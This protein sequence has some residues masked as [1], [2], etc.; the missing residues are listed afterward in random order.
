MVWLDPLAKCLNPPA[1]WLNPLTDS[2]SPLADEASPLSSYI[3]IEIFQN[4][5]NFS[6]SSC[7]CMLKKRL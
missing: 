5:L 6:I 3:F 7:V 2:S 1:D 4:F